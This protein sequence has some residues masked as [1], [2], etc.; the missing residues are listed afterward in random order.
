M[1]IVIAMALSLM[2]MVLCA[3]TLQAQRSA[4]R[5]AT[6]ATAGTKRPSS[7]A[8]SDSELASLKPDEGQVFMESV[9][10]GR[11]EVLS[12]PPLT[13]PDLSR[14]AGAR[15]RLLVQAMIEPT[16]RTDPRSLSSMKRPSRGSDERA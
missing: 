6:A 5:P 1:R 12:S 15:R 10:D 9:V 11:P 4:R 13:Y 3:S 16:V 14:Q 7:K 2:V 8:P